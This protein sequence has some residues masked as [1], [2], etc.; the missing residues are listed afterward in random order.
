MAALPSAVAGSG[1]L[2]LN[3]IRFD[4]PKS[5]RPLPAEASYFMVESL[6]DRRLALSPCHQ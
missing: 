6:G 1:R 2:L 3:D 4:K 5:N